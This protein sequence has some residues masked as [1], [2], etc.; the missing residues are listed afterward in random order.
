[1]N[2]TNNSFF[3]VVGYI[4]IS[5]F[6]LWSCGMGSDTWDASE[7]L[8]VSQNQLLF[9]NLSERKKLLI[10]NTSNHPINW[11]LEPSSNQIVSSPFAGLLPANGVA[12][13]EVWLVNVPVSDQPFQGLLSLKG[14]DRVAREI[15]ILA[16]ATQQ[17]RWTLDVSI[18]DAVYDPSRDV[19][20]ALSTDRRLLEID[21]V[22]KAIRSIP[23]EI[24]G[25]KLSIHP[26]GET[27]VV[28]HENAFSYLELPSGQ[29]IRRSPLPF[30][31]HDIAIAS[32][33]W[34]YITDSQAQHSRVFCV[35][36]LGNEIGYSP[37]APIYSNATISV[38]PSGD[39][40]LLSSTVITPD[41]VYKFNIEDGWASYQYDSPY[42]GD[43]RIGGQVWFNPKGDHF[44][45]RF[46][47]VF[48]FTEDPTRDLTY[49]TKAQAPNPFAFVR[50]GKKV[51]RIFAIHQHDFGYDFPG[52]KQPVLS[53][54]SSTYQ[55][56][57]SV[58]IPNVLRVVDGQIQYISTKILTG[59]LDKDEMHLY[60]LEKTMEWEG[61]PSVWSILT[62]ETH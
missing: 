43:Y 3:A 19:I 30:K 31:L 28:G 44:L 62:A 29:L 35:N 27:I 24:Q 61:A 26:D 40:L 20:W 4:L 11:S 10:I 36:L 1:M 39:Y 46:G 15:E 49:L 22:S 56:V 17:S 37:K 55:L 16:V 13:V 5:V 48:Q 60:M 42:H 6:F 47:H 2:F 32:N 23:L 25:I 12:E 53:V 54:Y 8:D 58:S 7:R 52:V 57:S 21:P 14:D 9:E 33:N 18:K 45:S 51:P 38:H 50:F 41:D 59:F 34:V